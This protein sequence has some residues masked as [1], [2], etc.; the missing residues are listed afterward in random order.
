MTGRNLAIQSPTGTGKVGEEGVWVWV[1]GRGVLR[2]GSHVC[3]E[4]RDTQ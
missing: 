2:E 3:R 4:A 1:C